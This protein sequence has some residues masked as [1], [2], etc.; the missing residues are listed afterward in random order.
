VVA[1]GWHSRRA[2]SGGVVAVVA[3]P[4]LLVWTRAHGLPAQR[5]ELT[6]GQAWLAS[7]AQGLVTLIDGPSNQVIGSVRVPPAAAGDLSVVQAGASAYVVSGP[8]GTV[9]R[10]DGATDE[11]SRPV[12]FGAGGAGGR[13][14]V[15]AGPSATYVVDG[16]RRLASVVDPR[17]MAVREQLGLAATP[18]AGQSAVD[19]SGR[20]WVVD[21]QGLAWFDRAGKH[22]AAEPGGAGR[23]LVLVQGRPVLVDAANSR[24]GALDRRGRVDKWSCLDV[25]AGDRAQLLGAADLDR[26]F[27]AVS[28][29]GQLV[30][31]GDG[32][33][34]CGQTVRIGQPGD[35]F[36]P[37]VEADG[38]VFVPNRSTGHTTVV[39]LAGL[40]LVADL[41][42]LKSG[43]GLE[44]LAKDGLVFYN[45]TLGDE[46]GVIN[47][48]GQRWSR[49]P[50]LT[51]YHA[52]SHGDKI[53]TPA[54]NAPAHGDQAGQIR[55]AGNGRRPP[56]ERQGKVPSHQPLP[57]PTQPDQPPGQAPVGVD[58]GTGVGGGSG[59]G[60]PPPGRP[61]PGQPAGPGAAIDSLTWAPSVVVWQRP[62][63]F[64]AK[65]RNA[66]GGRWAWTVQPVGG[67]PTMR[68]ATAGPWTVTLPANSPPQMQVTLTV[69]TAAGPVTMTQTFSTRAATAPAITDLTC[70]P[71]NP[72]PGAPV[73]C[74]GAEAN[75]GDRAPWSWT[76]ADEDSGTQLAAADQSAGQ[77]YVF[78]PPRQGRFQVR[79][80]VSFDGNTDRRLADVLTKVAVPPVVG[81]QR[82]DATGAISAAGLESTTN[83]VPS[84]TVPAGQVM[85]ADPAAGTLLPRGSTVTLTVST[86]STPP[87]DV[88][89]HAGDAAWGSGAGALPFPGADDDQRGFALIRPGTLLLEDGSHPTCLETHPQWMPN[90]YIT[91]D[92]TLPAPVIDGD[93]FRATIGFLAVAQPPSVGDATFSVQAVLPGGQ[94]ATLAQQFDRAD[95]GTLRDLDVDLSPVRGA[96]VIRLRVDAGASDHQD[97]AVWVRPRVEGG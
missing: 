69:T 61:P 81:R 56:D 19:G 11:V 15:F 40:R 92:F 94:V 48:D 52:A 82:D 59:P 44:L 80:A 88:L 95:D 76:V 54:G 12:Q 50:T 20:L 45:D 86:G 7:P 73:T 53:L 51:K 55:P 28:D 91:G 85:T 9:S 6:G 58:P 42:V 49:G 74:T 30:A 27:V 37:L 29:T 47:F 31:S 32:D 41:G 14:D 17:T 34:N 71:D 72:D 39:H 43:R 68:S 83:G 22:R 1:R 24:M 21:E 67:T 36:G 90:G 62:V 8:A 78:T 23:R 38:Y 87:Y 35:D 4:L 18:G 5:V 65:V 75:V 46:A 79:L 13:L 97:W 89:A 64:T 77:R 66:A 25:R 2:L 93:H 57:T 70:T 10:I 63:T 84:N 16:R 33:S 60:S 26:V 96:R 3:L